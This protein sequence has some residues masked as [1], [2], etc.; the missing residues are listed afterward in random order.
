MRDA[1]PCNPHLS[2]GAA[3]SMNPRVAVRAG[4]LSLSL[5][6]FLSLV[7]FILPQRI[8]QILSSSIAIELAAARSDGR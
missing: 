2:A 1:A 3:R 5:S 8:A 6:L 4:S 7:I